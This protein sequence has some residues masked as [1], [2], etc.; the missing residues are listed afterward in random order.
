[1]RAKI[2][3]S[4]LLATTVL[5]LSL[6]HAFA[7]DE[8]KTPA[9][10]A[11]V[12]STR[13]SRELLEVAKLTQSGVDEAVLLAFIEKNALQRSP[14]ADELVYLR[15]LGLSSKPMVALMN[16]V[17]TPTV[18][19]TAQA[20]PAPAQSVP[21]QTTV[22]A[23]PVVVAPANPPVVYVERPYVDY[24]YPAWSFGLHLGH[25]IF[26]HHGGHHSFGHHGG[27]HHGGHH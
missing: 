5:S 8:A 24:S 6:P 3:L 1:M 18:T 17:K 4:A 20:A 27:G 15:E 23:P 9:K 25:H 21:V 12:D 7:A 22:T 13:L 19:I 2:F 26:G 16:T 14:T 10:A 11:T